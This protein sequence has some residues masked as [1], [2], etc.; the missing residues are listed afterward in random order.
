MSRK[1]SRRVVLAVRTVKASATGL[2]AGTA[3]VVTL[4][5]ALANPP[6]EPPASTERSAR[7]A[8]NTDLDGRCVGAGG[9]AIIRTVS[10]R[11]R[12]VSFERGWQIYRG[13]RPGTLLAVC[14]D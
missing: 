6:A 5:G 1:P 7:L 10:G 14:P 4:S 12:T 9:D 11:T 13:K 3:I 2:L 8:E